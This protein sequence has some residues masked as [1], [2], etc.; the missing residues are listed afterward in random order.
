VIAWTVPVGIVI[1]PLFPLTGGVVEPVLL[2]P[3]VVPPQL[4]EPVSV[5][6]GRMV[7]DM[8]TVFA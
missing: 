2:K 6:G 5:T 3:V 7:R 1:T 8:V 4:C